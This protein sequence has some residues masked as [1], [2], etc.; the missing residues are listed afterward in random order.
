M[1]MFVQAMWRNGVGFDIESVDT[2]P[3][4]VWEEGQDP[5]EVEPSIGMFNGLVFTLPFI[6]IIVGRFV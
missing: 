1:R 2:L 3:L 5:A 4:W 6:K